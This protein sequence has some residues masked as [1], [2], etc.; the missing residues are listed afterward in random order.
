[1]THRESGVDAIGVAPADP[2]AFEVPVVDEVAEH[3]MRLAFGEACALGELADRRLGS[4]RDLD[5]ENRVGGDERPAVP[6]AHHLGIYSD[7]RIDST[8]ATSSAGVKG[9]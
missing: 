9:F 5:Q 2:L 8:A 7:A 4:P 3:A 6:G 1:M